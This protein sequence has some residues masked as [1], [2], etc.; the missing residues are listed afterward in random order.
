MT[1]S[2]MLLYLAIKLMSFTL[3]ICDFRFAA[4]LI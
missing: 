2:L 1:L 3:S 4:I